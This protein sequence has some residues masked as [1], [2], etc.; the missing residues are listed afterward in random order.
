MLV[1]RIK[2]IDTLGL[3]SGG[4]FTISDV[5]LVQWGRN[6][7]FGIEYQTTQPDNT[8]DASVSFRLI[9]RDCREM[10]WRSYAHIALSEMGEIALRT[11]LVDIALGHGNHRRDANILATHFAVTL[12]YGEIVLEHEGTTFTLI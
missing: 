10:K 1:D 4:T 5:E 8:L 3:I 2:I 7:E 9:F 12:S 11:E 6:L